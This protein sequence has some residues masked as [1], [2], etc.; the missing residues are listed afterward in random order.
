MPAALQDAIQN[1]NL[2]A[3]TAKVLLL[4]DIDAPHGQYPADIETFGAED[5]I[6]VVHGLAQQ[7]EEAEMEMAMGEK[8]LLLA[9]EAH[10][11]EVREAVTVPVLHIL[12]AAGALITRV[13]E[14]L[15]QHHRQEQEAVILEEILAAGAETVQEVQVIQE[16]AQ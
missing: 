16:Y 1:V 14:L 11:V 3:M 4:Q 8:N 7:A 15:I 10:L 2:I 6:V 9:E 12:G 5:G 13:Q